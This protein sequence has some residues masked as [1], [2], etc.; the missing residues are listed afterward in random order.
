MRRVFF[1]WIDRMLPCGRESRA[2]EQMNSGS[3]KTGWFV[4]VVLCC[5]VLGVVSGCGDDGVKK[6]DD[7]SGEMRVVSLSPAITQMIIDLG[8]A[9]NIVG[10][11]MHDPVKGE[12]VPV[13]GDLFNHDYEKMLGVEPT[14][15]FLQPGAVGV[16][17]KLRSLA[18]S[19]GWRIHEYEIETVDDVL[20][21]LS[22]GVMSVG[23][24][25]G[26]S[27]EAK[28]LRG[29]IEGKLERLGEAL[30]GVERERVLILIGVEPMTGVGSGTFLDEL[31]TIAGGVNVLDGVAS[32][33]PVLDL[34]RLI[35]LGPGVIVLPGRV[36][37]G[38]GGGE[39][40]AVLMKIDIPAVREGRV[41]WLRDKCSMLPS[42][43]MVRVAGKLAKLLHPELSETIDELMN[44]DD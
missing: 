18:D 31:L 43:S 34:E 16:P 21:T 37:G 42:T 28:K 4:F 26:V 1:D 2:G 25:L 13:V 30:K 24:V 14:D 32:H 29:E 7:A 27:E 20:E 3:N 36:E 15:I 8:M 12:S 41:L 6:G 33:Y 10:A 11:G 35:G 40:P 39:I 23:S 17:D 22:G 19:H 44:E 5:A 38:D 9:E